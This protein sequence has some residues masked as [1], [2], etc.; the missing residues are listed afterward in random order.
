MG[1]RIGQSRL[2]RVAEHLD[3]NIK[4]SEDDKSFLVMALL[5]ISNGED[6]EIALGVKAKKGERKGPYARDAKI[7]MQYVNALILALIAPESEEGLGLTLNDAVER[8]RR[9]W[10]SVPSKSTLLR[11][12]NDV[13]KTQSREFE[14]KTD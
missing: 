2:K 11:Y 12:W 9:D 10:P 6:A 5:N 8:V 13:R 4:L 14:I 3:Q 7:K 1:V